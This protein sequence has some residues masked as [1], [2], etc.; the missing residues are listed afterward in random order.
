MTLASDARRLSCFVTAEVGMRTQ[1]DRSAFCVCRCRV[2]LYRS[3]RSDK[4]LF[5]IGVATIAGSICYEAPEHPW[6]YWRAEPLRLDVRPELLDRIY[7][8]LLQR[9]QGTI[10]VVEATPFDLQSIGFQPVGSDHR[11]F[12]AGP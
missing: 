8:T 3:R 12:L 1:A 11:R 10:N 4:E 5:S 9:G 2:H 7:K 6:S